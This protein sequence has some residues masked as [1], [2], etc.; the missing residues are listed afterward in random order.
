[1]LACAYDLRYAVRLLRKSPGFTAVVVLT[2]AVGIGANTAIFSLL[3]SVLLKPL[4]FEDSKQLYVVHEIIPQWA[5]S[6]PVLDANLPDFQ[7]W[8]KES[9][10]FD[11]I[12]ILES[13]SMILAGVGETEQ[14]RGTRASAN[15]LQLLGVHPAIG[16][17]FLQNED[18]TDHGYSVILTNSFWRTRFKADP[19]I[20]G[21]SVM[22][23]EHP[24]TVVGVLSQSFEMPGGVNGLS[25]RSQ[26]LVPLN[27]P[28]YYE[29][30]LIGEFDF[31]A[32]GRLRKDVTRTQALA[33]LNVVQARIAKEAHA[34]LDLRAD[35]V[36]LQSQVVAS[37]QRGLIL[38][39]AAVGAV[40]L[41]ICVNLANLMFARLPGR[42]RE[43]GV[44]KALGAT[45]GRLFQQFLT[46]SLVIATIGGALGYLV[47]EIGV[48]W[49]A[50]F[51]P[52]G[53]P[54]LMEVRLD[55]RSLAFVVLATLGTATLF[56]VLPAWLASRADWHETTN[57]G[58][59][60]V[61]ENRRTRRLRSAL[62][63]AEAGIC[64]V[65]LI[66]AGLLGRS[67]LRLANLD[68]G[69]NVSN[70]LAANVDLPPVAYA[71]N[72]KRDRFYR[73]VL[74]GIRSLPGVRSV[75]WTH[76]LPLEGEGSVSGVNLP[77]NQLP[78]DQAPMANYRAVSD[79][80]FQ[81]MSIPILAGR[82]FDQHDRGQRRIIVSQSLAR[83]LWHDQNPIGEQCLAEWGSL[84]QSE[85]I[86]VAGNIRTYLD[87]PPLYMI[88]VADSWAQT[89]P[90]DPG[91]A[92]IVVRTI[93]DPAGVAAAVRTLI[94][95][96]DPTVPIVALR[97]MSEVVGENLQDR[98]FQTLLT[99]SFAISALLLA[100]IAIFGVLAYSVEQRR[101][102]FGI[103]TALGAQPAQLLAMI[104][105]QGLWPV[106]LG[107]AVGLVV[108][109]MGGRL[110]RDFVF[111]ISPFD[112]PTFVAVLMVVI[113]AATLACYIPARRAVKTE[114]AVVLRYE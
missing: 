1:M 7:I 35:I 82:A 64:A 84:E 66:V 8:R 29:Q 111:G 63:G 33:E 65:L 42:L 28:R 56:G 70:I 47:A 74:D 20:I 89:P 96:S 24:Y 10:S 97:P 87:Q 93:E 67:W 80:Y 102:E 57:S 75:A 4:N 59:R 22:L 91:S 110:L 100:S 37:S 81:T 51:G 108:A 98:R 52:A 13:T 69:F 34:D 31:T 30:D 54:R 12:A 46:E 104:M 26:F 113:S 55:A 114:P 62:V 85:V 48:L 3:N 68:P 90:G 19:A 103:R 78:E 44:R 61:S 49:L 45:E 6:A 40:L 73:S 36:P 15:L 88:Y 92:S 94:H 86:G 39:T 72:L 23:D 112:P 58:G 43:A 11:D 41:M 99:W 2:L 101:R 32:I 9:R 95:A 107:L 5:N 18:E 105:S 109:L 38:L 53:I 14:V 76:M 16:R 27:G 79:G 71:D 83:R 25:S 50:H 60:S 21:R 77:G 106:G 17:P